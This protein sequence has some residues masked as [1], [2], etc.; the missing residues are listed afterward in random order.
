[1]QWLWDVV[2]SGI[3]LGWKYIKSKA[4]IWY[5]SGK[6]HSIINVKVFSPIN[7]QALIFPSH[8]HEI[9]FISTIQGIHTT[10][11]LWLSWLAC[12]SVCVCGGGGGGGGM[13]QYKHQTIS[14]SLCLRSIYNISVSLLYCLFRAKRALTHNVLYHRITSLLLWTENDIQNI[15]FKFCFWFLPCTLNKWNLNCK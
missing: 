14:C 11:K 15:G 13:S 3:T 10:L 1:M 2:V 8:V 6:W 4:M 9:N 5:H 12:L 7:F